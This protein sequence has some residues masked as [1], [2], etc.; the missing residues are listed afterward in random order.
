MIGPDVVNDHW[1]APVL[2]SIARTFP[3]SPHEK[4]NPPAAVGALDAMAV[5]GWNVQSNF[6]SAGTVALE[7]AL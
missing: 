6:G 3:S 7:H 1:G 5:S 4:I 2:A